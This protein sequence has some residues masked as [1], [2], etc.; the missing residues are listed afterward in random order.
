[1]KVEIS[2]TI[3]KC[4]KKL[5]LDKGRLTNRFFHAKRPLDAFFLKPVNLQF[6]GADL[7]CVFLLKTEY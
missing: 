5:K 4:G 3:K 6:A 7:R 1:M 2:E